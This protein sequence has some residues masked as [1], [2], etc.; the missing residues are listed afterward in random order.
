MY[1]A[2]RAHYY[3]EMPTSDFPVIDIAGSEL[4]LGSRPFGN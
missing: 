4:R 3:W 2:G 1:L